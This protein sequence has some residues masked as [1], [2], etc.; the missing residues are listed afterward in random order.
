MSSDPDR[1]TNAAEDFFH[2]V[3]KAHIIAAAMEFFS[4]DDM[5]GIPQRNGLSTDTLFLPKE[6]KC[7]H[8]C[9]CFGVCK[10]IHLS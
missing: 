6:E 5:N 7:R 10:R 8:S 3:G 2:L 4:M 1:N 9:C